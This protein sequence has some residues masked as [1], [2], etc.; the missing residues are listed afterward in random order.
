VFGNTEHAA[1]L[2]GTSL[3]F[4]LGVPQK[5]G[6]RRRRKKKKKKKK[7]RLMCWITLEKKRQSV[8]HLFFLH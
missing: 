1:V 6:R 5:R 7:Q 2:H 8:H 3:L 4:G